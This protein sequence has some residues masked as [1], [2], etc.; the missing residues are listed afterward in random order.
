[1]S[2]SFSFNSPESYPLGPQQ[3]APTPASP[4]D[5]DLGRSGS[6]SANSGQSSYTSP[7]QRSV[8]HLPSL[9]G[10]R[11]TSSGQPEPS[12]P[13]TVKRKALP[14]KPGAVNA[15]P[16]LPVPTTLPTTPPSGAEEN[17]GIG[18][19]PAHAGA[20]AGSASANPSGTATDP[21]LAALEA[22]GQA[23]AAE[24]VSAVYD[25]DGSYDAAA[26]S[27][28]RTQQTIKQA[29]NRATMS[30]LTNTAGEHQRVSFMVGPHSI[31]DAL[32]QVM[33]RRGVPAEMFLTD[34][35]RVHQ[36]MIARDEADKKLYLLVALTCCL[37]APLLCC[38][39][40]ALETFKDK[41]HAHVR[42][43]N[44]RYVPYGITWGM[45]FIPYGG[46]FMSYET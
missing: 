23:L 25:N 31:P 14:A 29:A 18:T 15:P 10:S 44:L 2:S 19:S 42:E 13:T 37:A 33:A 26:T 16:P 27:S 41:L 30:A 1:M 6:A 5:A 45:E 35:Q 32:P 38:G 8:G 4:V 39:P 40:D 28:R 21:R 24:P 17:H 34:M 20:F 22:H 7:S 43:M 9:A 12:S 11:V 36:L 46:T 3:S